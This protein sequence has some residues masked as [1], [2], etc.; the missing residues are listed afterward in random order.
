M[1]AYRAFHFLLP[2]EIASDRTFIAYLVVR[3][4]MRAAAKLERSEDDERLARAVGS[5][6]GKRLRYRE[7]VAKV[8]EGAVQGRLF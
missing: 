8:P 2:D 3:D 5:A 6:E 1:L 4:Q 7:P